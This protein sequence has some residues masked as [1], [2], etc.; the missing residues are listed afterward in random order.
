[1]HF[2]KNYQRG[3]RLYVISLISFPFLSYVIINYTQVYM[4]AQVFFFWLN[5]Y[6]SYRT[7]FVHLFFCCCW[8]VHIFLFMSYSVLY[9]LN[10]PHLAFIIITIMLFNYFPGH[11]AM[12]ISQ[13]LLQIEL[14]KFI[15]KSQYSESSE[16]NKLYFW[17]DQNALVYMWDTYPIRKVSLIQKTLIVDKVSKLQAHNNWFNGWRQEVEIASIYFL[18]SWIMRCSDFYF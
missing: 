14:I 1:M 4:C 9:I 6:L 11:E 3:K 15:Q 17:N 7:I 5:V 13:L 8:N 2:V 18:S 12:S 16:L 10:I